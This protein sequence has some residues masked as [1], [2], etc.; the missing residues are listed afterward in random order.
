MYFENFPL[1]IWLFLINERPTRYTR[2]TYYT[3]KHPRTPYAPMSAQSDLRILDS[4]AILL[5]FYAVFVK[6]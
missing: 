1:V 4:F 2:S 3:R 5:D 6:I